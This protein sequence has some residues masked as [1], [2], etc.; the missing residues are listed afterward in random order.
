MLDQTIELP[1]FTNFGWIFLFF[2]VCLIAC[3]VILL[4]FFPLG[5]IAWKRVDY[6]WL[7]MALLGLLSGVGTARKIFAETYVQAEKRRIE[8]FY[9]AADLFADHATSKNAICL[10]RA[11]AQF[12]DSA[13]EE[14][15]REYLAQCEWFK[16]ALASLKGVPA[17]VELDPR[18]VFDPY[19]TGGDQEAYR[20]FFDFFS[21]YNSQVK[22]LSPLL[23]ESKPTVFE[24]IVRFLGPLAIAFALA[25]RMTKVSA[26]ITGEKSKRKMPF[27]WRD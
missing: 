3:H 9:E 6:I 22:A 14:R 17:F 13:S 11:P 16:K 23:E 8:S 27:E 25:L 20:E 10:E 2:I 21:S 24:N 18:V 26:E 5:S 12:G 4:R 19:P 15:Q 1:W 7:S